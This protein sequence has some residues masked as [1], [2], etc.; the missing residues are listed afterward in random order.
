MR[1]IKIAYISGPSFSDVDMSYLSYAQKEMN[2]TYFV[3]IFKN[4]L[5]GAAFNLHDHFPK[6]GIFSAVDTYPELVKFKNI[7]DLSK[8]YVI[9]NKKCRRGT[10]CKEPN[11][12]K[13]RGR[14]CRLPL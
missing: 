6:Y 3:P 4:G 11:S 2:I 7:I 1:P 9:M 5:R 10:I 8:F 14:K 12:C 13:V